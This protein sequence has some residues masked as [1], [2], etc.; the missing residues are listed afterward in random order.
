MN[1]ILF[2]AVVSTAFISSSAFA[3]SSTDSVDLNINATVNQECSIADP[4]DVVF[5][6]VNI[7]EGAGANALLLKNGSQS[8]TQNVYVSCN[9]AAKLSAASA[10][11]GL[12]NAAG[13]TLV[14]NDPNDFTD[15]IEYRIELTSTDNSFSKLDFRTNGHSQSNP[16][17]A[18]GAFHNEAKLKVY[19][20]R[21][22]TAKRPVAGTYTDTATLTVGPV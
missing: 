10:N 20:D 7:N 1:K 18:P 16:V 3:Q 13:A 11:G 8:N 6:E 12:F 19:I 21:D 2:A 17:N 22:D 5:A 15:L 9:Y 14:A 4:S